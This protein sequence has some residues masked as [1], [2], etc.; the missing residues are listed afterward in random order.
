VSLIPYTQRQSN[1]I[2][3]REFLRVD[4]GTV[5]SLGVRLREILLQEPIRARDMENVIVEVVECACNELI[6]GDS[7]ESRWNAFE[8][9]RRLYFMP[10][11]KS[12]LTRLGR[13]GGLLED[14]AEKI[15]N[16]YAL[17]C[18]PGA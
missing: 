14:V 12:A 17:F 2:D 3:S 8:L 5:I 15:F 7:P 9:L 4:D 10:M 16:K 13:S 6:D 18:T 1:E 11:T